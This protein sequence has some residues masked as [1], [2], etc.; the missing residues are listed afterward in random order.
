[1]RYAPIHYAMHK[2]CQ[3]FRFSELSTPYALCPLSTPLVIITKYEPNTLPATQSTPLVFTTKIWS[4]TL[5]I[6]LHTPH[7]LPTEVHLHHAVYHR[8]DYKIH[9]FSFAQVG[10]YNHVKLTT[11]NLVTYN[12]WFCHYMYHYKHHL[13]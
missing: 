9:N 4:N 6:P 12:F 5:L 2:P 3:Y 10:P 1:M 7:I 11:D 8:Q 13:S